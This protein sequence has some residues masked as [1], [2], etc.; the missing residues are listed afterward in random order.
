MQKINSL[1]FIPDNV[2]YVQRQTQSGGEEFLTLEE[3]I[4][5]NPEM[6]EKYRC[7]AKILSGTNLDRKKKTSANR[8]IKKAETTDINSQQTEFDPNSPKDWIINL[9]KNEIILDFGTPKN[10]SR[11]EAKMMSVKRIKYCLAKWELTE[12]ELNSPIM[13]NLYSR[14]M[15]KDITEY[16]KNQY[17]DKKRKEEQNE[18]ENMERRIKE[19]EIDRMNNPHRSS[20]VRSLGGV[21]ISETNPR[22]P[23]ATEE[24]VASDMDIT[25]FVTGKSTDREG[26][27]L[28]RLMGS[29]DGD[30]SIDD[31]SNMFSL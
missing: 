24:S 2:K 31:L 9:T 26:A 28:R 27:E 22:S 8:T 1:I 16:E 21:S 4:K 20:D 10:I 23:M 19:A 5:R 29:S 14:N 17:M 11:S 6:R 3:K 13:K 7:E 30:A 12:E 25:D 18:K 15:I